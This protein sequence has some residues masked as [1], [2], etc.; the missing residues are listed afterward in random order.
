MKRST[1]MALAL[2]VTTGL[3]LTAC[4][5]EKPAPG[6]GSGSTADAFTPV[7]IGEGYTTKGG[8]INVL[9]SSDFQ[10]LDPGNSNYVQTANVGQLYY[11]TLTM[12]KETAGQPPTIVPDLATDLG[13][14]SADGLTWTYTLKKRLKFEDGTPIT[15]K[16]IKYGVERT[17]ARDVYTQAPQE[18]NS[19]LADDGYKGP[20]TGGDFKAIDT[21]DDSTVVFH[22]KQPFAEFPALVSRS[23][24]APVPQAKDSKLDYTAHPVSSG[25]YKI[26][27]YDRGRSMKLVRNEQWDPATDPNRPALPDTFTFTLSTAQATIS[28]QLIAD[29]DPT[30]ITLDSN[31]GLQASDAAKLNEPKI[32][33]RTAAGLLGCTDVLDFNT[34]TI[35]D[36]QVRKAIALSIDRNAIQLQY[37]GARFG[38]VAQSY[39]NPAQ[40][41]YVEQHTDLDPGGKAKLDEA[42]KLLEG[43]DFP[44]TLVYGYA[45]TNTRYKNVGTVLQ[46]DL[47]ALGIDVQLRPIPAANY[48]TVLASDQ[49]PDIARSGWCGGADSGSVRTTIDPNVGPSVDGKTYGFSNIPRYY[50]PKISGE[51]YQL[52]GANGSSEE[53][54]KKWATLFDQAMQSYPLVPLV[55]TFTNSV[56][57]S[58]VRNAQV[59]Y[60][61]GAIDLSIVGVER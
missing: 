13:T 26:E 39:I 24:T 18:L 19:A 22:L 16:D 57:G 11:R 5:G 30:A 29:S 49:M 28:Q 41:G 20:Y 34:E 32:K 48:Y 9:M 50:D 43:K 52:R 54:G 55:R 17:Y 51:M 38:K 53:L 15:S 8:N 60:F 23:N 61:F 12:A 7:K 27:S 40:R 31:G 37:G 36:P 59:G 35:K 46:Q 58:K 21:P 3:A 4:G 47:K 1:T 45:D 6:S 42:K 10:T 25:P 44:K 2:T 33:E 56:V 14:P